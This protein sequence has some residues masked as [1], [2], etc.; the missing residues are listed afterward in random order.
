MRNAKKK[1]EIEETK[2]C[3]SFCDKINS[4]DYYYY[5][6]TIESQN[7]KKYLLNCPN[8]KPF[9]KED[10]QCYDSCNINSYNY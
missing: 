8:A 3:S 2:K 7:I 1:I 5:I 10:N 9:L 6:D 4:V